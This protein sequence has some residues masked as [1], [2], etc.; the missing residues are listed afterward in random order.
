MYIKTTGFFFL[1][2]KGG[3]YYVQKLQDRCIA[4]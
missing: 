3:F 4:R 2:S 1:N